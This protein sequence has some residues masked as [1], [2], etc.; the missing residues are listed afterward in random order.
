MSLLRE[1]GNELALS[2]CDSKAQELDNLFV[3][4]LHN[5]DVW[6]GNKLKLEF[7]GHQW[8][9]DGAMYLQ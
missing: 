2:C 1:N 3:L 6:V 4:T 7:T 9:V 5:L 8:S